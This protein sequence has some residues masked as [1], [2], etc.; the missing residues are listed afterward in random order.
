MKHWECSWQ[1][2][3]QTCSTSTLAGGTRWSLAQRRGA[4]PRADRAGGPEV[5]PGEGRSRWTRPSSSA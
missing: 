4:R 2:P 1:R 3:E 5:P